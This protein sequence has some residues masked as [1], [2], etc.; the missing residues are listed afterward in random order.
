MVKVLDDRIGEPRVSKMAGA[1]FDMQL[2]VETQCVRFFD[3][4][5]PVCTET[6]AA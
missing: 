5:A 1:A 4:E 3:A 6:L 2:V